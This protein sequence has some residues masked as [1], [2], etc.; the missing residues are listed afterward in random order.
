[1]LYKFK[2]L[3][4]RHEKFADFLLK[5]INPVRDWK[6][7]RFSKKIIHSR[8]PGERVVFY[9][10]IPAHENLGDLAQG[11][12]IRKWLRK[13]YQDWHIMEVETNALVNTKFSVLPMLKE[14]YRQ[15]DL[16]LFQS[17]YTTTDL[18]G[19]A[20]EMH[21][22]VMEILPQA[23][24]LMMPQT[25]FFQKEENQ[26]RTSKVYNSMAH[27][28]YL[29]RDEVSFRMAQQMFPDLPVKLYP[30][31]VT[32]MIGSRTYSYERTG[33]MM[34]CRDDGE[35]F[36]ADEELAMLAEH[37]REFAQVDRTDT[38]KILD[39]VDIVSQAE[40]YIQN[41]IDTYAHYKVMITDRYHGT[42][43]SL[44]AGTPVIVLKTT[45][46][47]VTTGAAWFQGVY[48]DY[49][50]LAED[51]Q[52]ALQLA[53]I[54]YQKDLTNKLSPYFEEAY[55]DRLPELVNHILGV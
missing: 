4:T 31:I 48:D 26:L 53:R 54:L 34:C 38:T 9:L 27:L 18:G 10:G 7:Y 24:M 19:Y 43:L 11:V 40:Q 15:G 25:I 37:C 52:E 29:V 20:D 14:N 49:V 32:T 28:L 30:D 22:A 17:G 55:Y 46:H 35:K 45:D 12:C 8:R 13:H 50:Y 3:I 16:I 5:F 2:K 1:M 41:E 33:I 23:R 42:I 36:Y 6:R 21:R 39:G 51:L 47:K 44:V